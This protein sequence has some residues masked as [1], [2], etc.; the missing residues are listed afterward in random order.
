MIFRKR[1]NLLD[2]LKKRQQE[3]FQAACIGRDKEILLFQENVKSSPEARQWYL[4]N[5]YGQAG[6]GKTFLMQ[7]FCQVAEEHK[8]LTAW[9][10]EHQR[11][12]LDVMVRI[13]DELKQQGIKAKAFHERYKKYRQLRA[14]LEADPTAPK[15]TVEFFGSMATK[16]A[17]EW[18]S[19]R[20]GL[21]GLSD[22]IKDKASAWAGEYLAFIMRKFKKT[23]DVELLREPITVL[24]PLWLAGL[25][26]Q[27]SRRSIV[28]FLDS[29]EQT[30]EYLDKWLLELLRQGYGEVPAN[31][32]FV[33]AGQMGLER[34]AWKK[35]QGAILPM[36]LE[37][38]TEDQTRSCLSRSR[39]VNE[40]LAADI[41]RLT[42]G[43]PVLVASL[44]IERG[45][46]AVVIDPHATVLDY[47]LK[48][49]SPQQ[50]LL[51]VDAALPR[52]LNRDV[53]VQLMAPAEVDSFSVWLKSR[54]FALKRTGG[55]EYHSVFR[56]LML[57]HKRNES[58][59]G[60]AELHQRLGAY[61][62][63]LQADLGLGDEEREKD[64]VW[65]KYALEELY[66]RLCENPRR[67]RSHALNG[68]LSALKSQR[69]FAIS[70]AETLQQ[71]EEDA[72]VLAP[73]RWGRQLLSAL[74]GYQEGRFQEST[75]PFTRLLNE[76]CI[77]QKMR[78][79][80]L[81]WRGYLFY[82]ARNLE[83]ALRSLSEAVT[84]DPDESE[85]LLDRSR[86]FVVLGRINDALTSLD[87]A[88]EKEP[89]ALGCIVMRCMVYMRLGRIEESIADARKLR[90]LR[91]DDLSLLAVDLLPLLAT[92]DFNRASDVSS[93][94]LNQLPRFM[95]QFREG[96][97]ARP[98]EVMRLELE[99]L[100]LA[101][102]MPADYSR[103]AAERSLTFAQ[104]NPMFLANAFRA[105]MAGFKGAHYL[106]SGQP[107]LAVEVFTEAIDL[108]PSD[109]FLL[110]VR[111]Q[112][113]VQMSQFEAALEDHNRA[114][115]LAPT[116]A[117][118]VFAR[119]DFHF[120]RG[121]YEDALRDL[122]CAAKLH[123]TVNNLN[124]LSSVLCVLRRW[125]EALAA[126]RQA[127]ELKPDD[128]MLRFGQ[129]SLLRAVGDLAGVVAVYA[130]LAERA[131]DFTHQLHASLSVSDRKR[132]LDSIH[133]W[134]LSMGLLPSSEPDLVEILVEISDGNLGVGIR[135][136]EAY[137]LSSRAALLH[138]KKRHEEA[139][140][141][142]GQAAAIDP[143]NLSYLLKRAE[144]FMALGRAEEHRVEV[145][146]I[147]SV[148]P[149]FAFSLCIQ[150]KLFLSLAR[151]Q[152]AK[153]VCALA[154]ARRLDLDA[155]R[156]FVWTVQL[157][158]GEY[159]TV[160]SSIHDFLA[161]HPN[162]LS[163]HQ[164]RI[165]LH[166]LLNRHDEAIAELDLL[167]SRDVTSFRQWQELRGEI[168]ASCG[169]YA[170]A[171]ECHIQVLARAPE[172]WRAALGLLTSRLRSEGR[173]AN[174]E[175]VAEVRALLLAAPE[176]TDKALLL[177]RRAGLEALARNV[178]QALELLQQVVILNPILVRMANAEP[179]WLELREDPRFQSLL[180][181]ATP[182]LQA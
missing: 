37:P 25:R 131:A 161:D 156:T 43:L 10:D 49:G 98:P 53:L 72:A 82:L 110:L 172:N 40:Q 80:A 90:E 162:E 101:M 69:A 15:G 97:G 78:A 113:Y 6:F 88:I 99:F 130:H 84:L 100:F 140:A 159:E 39:P 14:E 79:V 111:A 93:R 34:D 177:A 13:A 128:L 166:W 132:K 27:G 8:A 68:F 120:T 22:P 7:R 143:D 33:V 19:K 47:F 65:Q 9:S 48:G 74:K 87:R 29:H 107:E 59:A 41:F 32:L 135:A 163:A 179:A 114:V 62:S 127:S 153:E 133:N 109:P 26:E 158:L 171:M 180:S 63:K 70:W 17:L 71:A 42:Q 155:V 164:L 147:L 75:E 46:D 91:P 141:A 2:L 31:I 176:T 85:Y 151:Y 60:W 129:I 115:E 116:L 5:I 77:E 35:H 57:E 96:M 136:F 160:L 58:L 145:Q 173:P 122:D 89:D 50:R 124:R 174:A 126:K 30:S 1:T 170:E 146:R 102:G 152:K 66:H 119:G 121:S 103:T 137:A 112:A 20:L 167:V 86:V 169:R 73:L 4:C 139:L 149:Q 64:S 182:Q 95:Q 21:E 83:D 51:A 181:R 165:M 11:G 157:L 61:Y 16:L 118:P 55:W 123:P 38:F 52:R 125:P 134:I 106:R 104:S 18:S 94:I 36:P 138:E 117:E 175:E 56:P 144:L 108:N 168:L 23:D 54:G 45:S 81:N 67:A 28:L 24:T 3:E 12:V 44:S 154:L 105:A 178:E 142:Y 92:G 148:Q 150:A 76:D